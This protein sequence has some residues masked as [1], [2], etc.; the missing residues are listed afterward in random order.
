MRRGS[1]AQAITY[2]RKQES[3]MSGD[4]GPW[5]L[6]RR[7]R[8]GSPQSIT[9]FIE[10]VRS[11]KRRVDL[12]DSHPNIMARHSTFFWTIRQTMAWP[13]VLDRKV[14]LYFGKT[15]TGKTKKATLHADYWLSPICDKKQWFDGYDGQK[16]AILDEFKGS[17]KRRNLLR[18]LDVQCPM[19]EVKHGFTPWV[20]KKIIITSNYVPREWYN[21]WEGMEE[22]YK[23][24]C[25]R[26]TKIYQFT[27]VDVYTKYKDIE[28][29]KILGLF[30]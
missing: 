29:N 28:K 12:L 26:I 5:E 17:M 10:A 16:V 8:Q 7:K 22:T 30:P 23:A 24:L 11:K 2:C 6:G 19:V 1:Q 13:P 4:S 18:L 3:R 25:R 27:A 14:H 15:G 21:S 20:P 9:S